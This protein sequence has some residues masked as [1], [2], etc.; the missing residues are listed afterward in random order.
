MM[1][2]YWSYAEL[3]QQYYPDPPV[4]TDQMIIDDGDIIRPKGLWLGHPKS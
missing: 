2:T 3:L 4:D 1:T